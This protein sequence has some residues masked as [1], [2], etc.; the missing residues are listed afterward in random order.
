MFSFNNP[1]G[2]CP[3]CHGLGQHHEGGPG[4][5]RARSFALPER[6]RHPCFRLETP[7]PGT[8]GGVQYFKGMAEQFGFSMDTPFK[9]L[10]KKV[11]DMIFYGT[12]GERFKVEYS[13]N[14]GSGTFFNTFEG[15]I[16]N[17]ERRYRE[18]SSDMMKEEIESYMNA[19]PCPECKGAR[20]KP[21][22]LAV[23]IGGINIAELSEKSVT[24][25]MAFFDRLKLTQKQLIIAERVQKELKARLNFLV[26]V[27]LNYLTLSR[28]A[29]SLSG[30]E[31]QRIRL[32]TQ[33]GSG[34]V[35]V[36]YILDEPSIGLH[37]RDNQKLLNTLKSLR[38]LGNTLIV[39]EHD[40]ETILTADYV[41]DIGPGAGVHGGYIVASG[42]PQEIMANADSVTGQ[43]LSGARMIEVPAERRSPK[44]W[45][46]VKGARGKQP[47]KYRCGLPLRRDHGRNGRFRQRQIHARERDTLQGDSE[48]AVRHQGQAGPF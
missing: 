37:Q 16:N 43:F 36:L 5:H 12:N 3:H 10:P 33:I 20:L 35:G 29:G 42:T 30:G 34:L 23:K 24:D 39:V 8:V 44:G 45:L 40:E 26:D 17:L 13:S 19:I 11:Q 48:K 18:T 27:G 1:Y 21:E 25:I 9:D 32:A 6:R 7:H 2:A 31:A 28:A 38:D 22:S 4:H 41:L 14:Y 46:T 15:I 47:E